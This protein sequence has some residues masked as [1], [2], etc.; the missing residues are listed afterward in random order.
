M[1]TLYLH[2]VLIVFTACSLSAQDDHNSQW[3]GQ[4]RDGIYHESGLLKSWGVNGPDLL[5]KYDNLGEGHSSVA[6]SNN[7]VYVT[8]LNAD[9]AK[10]FVFDI[11]GSLLKEK[12]YAEEWVDNFEGPRSTITINDGMLYLYSGLGELICLDQKTL[13]EVWKTN[14]ITDL[15]GNN[16]SWGVTESPLIVDEK[17]II[18]SGGTTNNVIALHKKTGKMIWKSEAL[19]EKSAYCS[20][21]LINKYE[22]PIIVTVT[23]ISLIGLN[24]NTGKVLWNNFNPTPYGIQANTPLFIKEDFIFFSNAEGAIMLRI[25]DNGKSIEK[26]WERPEFNNFMGGY[27]VVGDYI[28]GAGDRKNPWLCL[29]KKTGKI[30]YSSKEI[31]APGNIISADGKLY[32]YSDRGDFALVNPTPEKFDIISRF[33]IAYGTKQHWAHPVIKNGILYIRHGNSL[34]A[35]QI[36]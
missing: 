17:V 20:P 35:Y 22:I 1:K 28:Y 5:W 6:I 33:K 15:S 24:A 30:K 9:E 3:R 19:A 26:L 2:L 23:E 18:T 8:G 10:L 4:N 27:V 29:D 21:L 34:M 7:K 14:V 12:V 31:N 25:T 36:K 32:C 13:N 16:I 11:N